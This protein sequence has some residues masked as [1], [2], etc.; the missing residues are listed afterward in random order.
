MDMAAQAARGNSKPFGG[1]QL[2][3]CGDFLQLPPVDKSEYLQTLA[4]NL[5]LIPI[6]N[7][8]LLLFLLLKIFPSC[9]QR[10]LDRADRDMYVHTCLPHSW[11]SD[12]L[13]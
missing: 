12:V 10:R 2:I 3:L 8:S 4:C 5:G 11:E 9:L 13:L 1:I 6:S 7:F